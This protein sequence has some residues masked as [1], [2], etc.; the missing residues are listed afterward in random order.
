MSGCCDYSFG[1]VPLT[2]G[3]VPDGGWEDCTITMLRVLLGDLSDPPQYTDDRLLQIL[4]TSAYFVLLDLACCSTV[5]KPDIDVC[6]TLSGDPL[7]HPG[8]TNLMVL[9]AGCLID[10]AAFRIKAASEGVRAVAG[11]VSIQTG[12]SASSYKL[13]FENGPCSAYNQLKEDLC[14]R[15]PAQSAAWCG[16][17]LGPYVGLGNLSGSDACCPDSSDQQWTETGW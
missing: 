17:V 15:C 1:D 3:E 13:L 8:F 4:N 10:G 11:P 7:E 9:K 6:G 2:S 16:Q 5:S 12:S 14:M